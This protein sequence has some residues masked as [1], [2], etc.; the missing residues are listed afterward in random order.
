MSRILKLLPLIALVLLVL[1]L[2]SFSGSWLIARKVIAHL[3]MPAGVLWVAGLAAVC[4]PGLGKRARW[5]LGVAWIGYTL[6]GSP[7]VGGGLL[8]ATE[9]RY[10]QYEDPSGYFDAVVVLGGGTAQSPG[11][12]P[13]VGAH[14]DRILQP[15][16][17]Y[18]RGQIGVLIATG[19][20]VTERREDRDLSREASEIWQSLGIPGGAI[21]ELSEPRNTAE[22]LSAVAGVIKEHPEWKRV[23]LCSSASHLKRALMEADAQGLDLEP[24]PSD[25]R[26]PP[27]SMSPIHWIP[28]GR[29]VRDVQTAAW[30]FLGSLF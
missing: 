22:E 15:A 16:I 27:S 13:V 14:G 23:G 28:Q 26:L 20:S 8:R 9:S 17:L 7:Y 25:F 19:R 1:I 24:V 5:T 10:Y 4:W 21:I 12:N 3:M 29:G 11:G 30:E 6:A 18:H 2:M